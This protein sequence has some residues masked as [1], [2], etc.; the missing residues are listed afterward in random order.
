MCRVRVAEKGLLRHVNWLPSTVPTPWRQ[1]SAQLNTLRVRFPGEY[2]SIFAFPIVAALERERTRGTSAGYADVGIS[3][4]SS[5]TSPTASPTRS[6]PRSP[7][8][9][10]P[11][12]TSPT[13]TSPGRTPGAGAR[14]GP[15]PSRCGLL[16]AGRAGRDPHDHPARRAADAGPHAP[17]HQLDRVDDRDLPRSCRQR[18]NAGRTGRWCC[19]G[20]PPGWVRRPSSP[21]AST[22]SYT[23]PPCASRSN[24]PRLPLSHPPATTRRTLPD[25]F[26]AATEVPRNSGH[27]PYDLAI[28]MREWSSELLE[29]DP[30]R[31]GRERSGL[32]GQLTGVDVQAI[33]EWGFVERVSIGLLAMQVGAEVVGRRMLEVAHHWAQG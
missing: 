4:I 8:S 6:A 20:S 1:R 27:P 14:A 19:A 10:V 17:K 2:L 26:R 29:G 7:R 24:G 5:A 25:Q 21:A 12:T 11:P 31:L 9:C 13:A 15:L 22:G 18:P 28:P 33:W 32:L 30:A 23:W 3:S 16:P